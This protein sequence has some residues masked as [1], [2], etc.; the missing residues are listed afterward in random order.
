MHTEENSRFA[1]THE[2]AHT[3]G[4]IATVGISNHAQ[5]EI[6]DIVFVDLP[7][8][9]QQVTAGQNCCVIES[10]KSASEIYA[11]VSGEIVEVNE[12]LNGDPALVN[13]EP[14]G[15]GWLFKIKM[16]TPAE[17][18]NLLDLSAYKATIQK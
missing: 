11:P 9:G 18:E 2:W 3:E 10:V 16:T 14:H 5:E 13:R 1:K 4:D 15:N 8:V 6:S 12:A 17:Y 7:K